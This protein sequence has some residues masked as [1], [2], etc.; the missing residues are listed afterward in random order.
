[1]KRLGWP[2]LVVFLV[3]GCGGGG[4]TEPEPPTIEPPPP[5]ANRAPTAVGSLQ[6]LTIEV[7]V[8]V[9]VN[10]ASNFSDPDGDALAYAASSS[11]AAVATPSVSGS[12]VTVTGVGAGMANITVTA[13]DPGGLSATQTM[14]VTVE[15]ANQAPVPVGSLDTLTIEVGVEVMVNVASNF[16]DPDGDAL[17]YSAETSDAEVASASVSGSTLSVTGIGVGMADITVTATDPDGLSAT[18]L[19]AVTVEAVNLPPVVV[20]TLGDQTMKVGDALTADIA[21]FFEDPEGD[22]LSFRAVSAD[23]M[24]ATTSTAGSALMVVAV[25]E[26]TAAVEVRATDTE[27]NFAAF[28]FEVTV[29]KASSSI[30]GQVTIEGEGLAGVTVSLHGG[31]DNVSDTTMTDAAGQY[32]FTNLR[33]GN[34]RV[35]VSGYDDFAYAFEVTSQNVTLG[36]DETAVVPFVGVLLRGQSIR[37]RVSVEGKGLEGVTV[38]LSITGFEPIR[39]VTDAN[40]QYGFDGLAAGNYTVSIS[41]YD[42][43]VYRFDVTSKNVTL[44]EDQ[45]VVVDFEGVRVSSSTVCPPGSSTWMGIPVCTEGSRNNYDRD[46]L[47]TGYRSLEDEVI[48]SLPPI[49][50]SVYTPY[51]STLYE[52]RDGGTAAT[53]HRPYCGAGGSLRFRARLGFV[54]RLRQGLGEPDDCRSF[55]EPE[56]EIG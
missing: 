25:A 46:D 40:G 55:G 35:G 53:R 26:G 16:N 43:N 51:T 13:T 47:R 23:T 39:A 17:T 28:R 2:V 21:E 41:G 15:P 56:S 24:V 44:G 7:G 29:R 19:M 38:T 49:R 10:V 11:N 48:D 50:D 37:G 8:E 27:D 12:V 34:Y 42:T 32:S 36:D 4:G 33:A 54:P 20:G 14:G 30:R 18:Q 31:P 45:R 3:G 1:M 9:M 6:S 5:P 22:A 52:I